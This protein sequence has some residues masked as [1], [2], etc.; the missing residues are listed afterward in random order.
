MSNYL[1]SGGEVGVSPRKAC[2]DLSGRDKLR[3][4]A[5]PS[6]DFTG[7]RRHGL[8]FEGQEPEEM[9]EEQLCNVNHRWEEFFLKK[10]GIL[11]GFTRGNEDL[12]SIGLLSVRRTLC[13]Y[14]DCPESWLVRR[15]KLDIM[16]A[17]KWGQSVDSAT[18]DRQR[19]EPFYRSSMRADAVGQSIEVAIFDKLQYEEFLQDLTPMEQ[20][21]VELLKQEKG[22]KARWYKGEYVPVLRE[23]GQGRK[24]FHQEVSPSVKDYM[25]SY[26]H[27]RFKFY[28][29]FGEEWEIKREREWLENWQPYQSLHASRNG[30]CKRKN[31]KV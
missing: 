5:T 17:A 30:K 22:D 6:D 18:K 7:K 20:R 14:P 9:T 1:P 12:V 3:E 13:L 10:K 27:A 29:H 24:R 8:P 2:P 25:V 19:K 28:L 16:N 31:Q 4:R 23:K 26:A 21:L 11:D 15:A